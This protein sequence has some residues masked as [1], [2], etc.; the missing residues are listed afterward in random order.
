M[1]TPGSTTNRSQIHSIRYK[2]PPLASSNISDPWQAVNGGLLRWINFQSNELQNYR[3]TEEVNAF[4]V[5]QTMS[6]WPPLKTK[7]LMGRSSPSHIHS[8][9]QEWIASL[10][11]KSPNWTNTQKKTIR[12]MYY[13]EFV[14][15]KMN[16]IW[17]S[18]KKHREKSFSRG[19]LLTY[20]DVKQIWRI[21]SFV[22]VCIWQLLL[23]VA[24]VCFGF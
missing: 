16:V 15:N 18:E 23:G 8:I 14:C 24:M 10:L 9:G 19:K 6:T 5:T 13:L 20:F 11:L 21:N 4:C 12:F 22:Y 1:I 2:G 3:I 17:R 7:H